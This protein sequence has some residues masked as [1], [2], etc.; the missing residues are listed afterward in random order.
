MEIISFLAIFVNAGLVT[1]TTLTF[2]EFK[3]L[4]PDDDIG[5]IRVKSFVGLIFVCIFVK[6][7]V[8]TLIDDVP[9]NIRNL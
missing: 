2:D 1:W 5:T 3:S 7:F 6:W 9:Y 4:Y 8:A